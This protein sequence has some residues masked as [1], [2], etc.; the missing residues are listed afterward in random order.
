[1]ELQCSQ[2]II[3]PWQPGDEDSIV[4]QANNRKIWRNLRDRFPHPYTMNDAKQWVQHASTEHP[5]TSFAIVVDGEAVGGIGL[6][7]KDDVYR[8]SAE[9]GYWLGEAFWGRGIVT[10]AVRVFTD[11]AF[12]NFQFC[13]IFAHVYEWNPGSMRVLEKA[14]YQFEARMRKSVFK[15]GQVIDEMVY[16]ILREA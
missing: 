7:L 3:R 5:L 11:Y 4:R 15:D 13:R 10:E 1:M 6:L 14:G 16:A 9:I 12:A 8:Q 2:F